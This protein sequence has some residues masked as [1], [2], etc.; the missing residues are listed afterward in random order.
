MCSNVFTHCW[1]SRFISL[2][3]LTGKIPEN[4]GTKVTKRRRRQSYCDMLS[5]NHLAF[6]SQLQV[7]SQSYF[8]PVSHISLHDRLRGLIVVQPN[9]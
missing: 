4:S 2:H 3:Q 7:A 1:D 8:S 9:H 6:S 5:V